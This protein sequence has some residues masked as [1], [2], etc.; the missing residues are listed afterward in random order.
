MKIFK[1]NQH[2]NKKNNQYSISNLTKNVALSLALSM[3]ASFVSFA[4]STA[5]PDDDWLHVEGNQILDAQG[6]KVWLTGA[7]WF[8]FNTSERVLHGLW[9]VNLESTINAI[10][11]RGI[12]LLR[13][14]ISTELLHEWQSGVT[15]IAQ[16]NASANP[17]LQGATTL[18]VFDALVDA[19]RNAGLKILLD[20]HGAE[21]DNMG[22]IY[23]MWYK[24][25]FSDE[26]FYSTWE[27]VT[28]R[29]KNDDTILAFDLE[30]EPHGKPWADNEFAK[31]DNST[32]V[33]N[34]K[35]ACE[36]AANRILDI[37]PNMLIMCEG[38]ESYPKDS[39]SWDATS[40]SDFHNNWWGGNLRP[41]KDFPID[42]GDR[43][44]Q[45][46]Y[47]P[48]DYGPLVFQQ[49]WFYPG[50][51]KE[52][53]YQDVWKDN[54][55]FIHEENISPLLIGEWGGFM[56]GGDNEKWMI[57]MQELILEYGLHHT[58][59]CIN[60]NSGDTGGLL[61]NSWVSWDEEKY[62]ILEPTLWK[63]NAGKFIGLDHQVPLG[64]SITGISLNEHY[65]S[66]NPAEPAVTI[67][68]PQSGSEVNLGST[69]ILAYDLRQANSVNVY[70]N[71]QLIGTGSSTNASITAPNTE[72][73]FTVVL[74]AVNAQGQELSAYASIILNAVAEV[75]NQ[76]SIDIVQ[77][78]SDSTVIAGSELS[79][80]ID[81]QEASGFAYQL[82]DQS[83]QVSGTQALISVPSTLGN[84][85]LTVTALD[86]NN[87]ALSA[88]DEINL[89][90]EAAVT[91]SAIGCEIG[92]TDTWNSGFVIN[93][94]TITNNGTTSI[95]TWAITLNFADN[96]T[97]V[98]G[99]SGQYAQ[100]GQKITVSNMPY[101][102]QLAPGQSA[103]I[104]LQ[105]EKS[106]EFQAPACIAQ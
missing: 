57:A 72:G 102:G 77:P 12:N 58:F 53:L 87:Q 38:I 81:L 13:V 44:S 69:I 93:D 101:N 54:W 48:H 17:S 28:E 7:N 98:N 95:S 68:S 83:G 27:W 21:A 32:D 55:M 82:G 84:Y 3:T 49:P 36:T 9:S 99:W 6:N 37:N 60:P 90:V 14:P 52:T 15:T 10:A 11:A 1:N 63:N 67:Q 18:E 96:T 35:Y 70:A 22:H 16:I 80:M 46:M 40:D 97:F 91:D 43:Q 31:W 78:I 33:N 103:S 4:N 89:T 51:N 47:S 56:D 29:Y 66:T 2:Y 74:K 42:L 85:L 30:N 71:N 94:I 59:W 86:E 79:I 24:G 106:G 26:V 34:W 76:P 62:A 25:E 23:P 45:F 8:G 20:V 39:V 41:V 61:D 64:S 100:S 92:R 73:N 5:V 19:S 105:G 65:G 104:G 75:I 88:T 50:F